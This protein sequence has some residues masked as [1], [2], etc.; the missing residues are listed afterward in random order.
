MIGLS[1]AVLLT[2][3]HA[4]RAVEIAIRTRLGAL[5]VELVVDDNSRTPVRVNLTG[6]RNQLGIRSV[7]RIFCRLVRFGVALLGRLGDL[8][9]ERNVGHGFSRVKSVLFA[10]NANSVFDILLNTSSHGLLGGR[11]DCESDAHS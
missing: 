8:D 6:P 11:A 5:T 10:E 3:L 2:L 7:F 4:G 1:G 9:L